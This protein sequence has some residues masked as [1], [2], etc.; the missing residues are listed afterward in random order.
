M[1][2]KLNTSLRLLVVGLLIYPLPIAI[3][4]EV[5]VN[6]DFTDNTYQAGLTISGGN[7]NA[8]IYTTENNQ[9]GTTGNSLGISSGTYSFEFSSD[10]DVYEVGFIVG[11]VNGTWSIKWYYADGTD[12]TVNKNAQSNSNLSTM[13]ETIYKSY[14]D[15]NAVDGN[16]D[17]FITK[18]EVILSDLS[19]LDTLYWQYDDSTSTGSFA[20]T[21]TTTL[22]SG[23]GDPTNL[24]TSANLHTGAISIDWDAATGY[25]Y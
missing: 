1:L 9:Y 12:E 10:I 23:I 2:N 3:A 6:E 8:F 11:A 14:T 16:T 7:S 13:Y 25:Q 20:T 15:Y 24:T 4:Q 19:L 5:T 21:T 17:K 22:V 18:F